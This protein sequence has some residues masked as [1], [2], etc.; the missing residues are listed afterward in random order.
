[1][2]DGKTMTV[3][4]GVTW[5][6]PADYSAVIASGGALIVNGTLEVSGTL[7]VAGT[8]TVNGT[9]TGKVQGNGSTEDEWGKISYPAVG[10]GVGSPMVIDSVD[11]LTFGVSGDSKTVEWT[12][13]HLY[14]GDGKTMTV[15]AGVTWTFP[16]GYE[17]TIADGGT[18]KVEGGLV[19]RGTVTV[20]PGGALTVAEGAISNENDGTIGGGGTYPGKT[21]TG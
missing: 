5:V 9:L 16:S 21:A 1:V 12:S 17:V 4:A 6:F 20:A 7:T 2:G 10:V 14:V 13:G 18:L 3:P 8:L 15:P 19:N 11:S